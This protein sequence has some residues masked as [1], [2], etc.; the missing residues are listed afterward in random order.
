MDNLI[1]APEQADAH[2][3]LVAT[4]MARAALAGFELVEL[5]DGSF[6]AS[7]WSLFRS[8][9]HPAAV[10]QFLRRIGAPE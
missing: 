1:A 9:E 10:E 2:R 3:K 5:A 7:R 6:I 4:L 8:F